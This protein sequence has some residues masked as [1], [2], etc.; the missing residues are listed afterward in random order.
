[1]AGE[2]Q[3]EGTAK[4]DAIDGCHPWL[5]ARLQ[6]AIELREAARPIEKGLH[7][8]LLAFCFRH[9]RELAGEGF[10]HGQVGTTGE[11]LLAGSDD[12]ALERGL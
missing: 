7:G 8:L 9:L 12:A 3:L 5:S 6:L 4:A 11:G 10:E 1:M 2:R